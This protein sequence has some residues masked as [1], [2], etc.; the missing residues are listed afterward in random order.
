MINR[1]RIMIAERRFHPEDVVIL[2]VDRNSMG[3]FV[4]RIELDDAGDFQSPWPDG[5]FDERYKDTMRLSQLKAAK[6]DHARR[7]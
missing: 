2:Y 1:L 6:E 3:S 5:F 7:R 4:T